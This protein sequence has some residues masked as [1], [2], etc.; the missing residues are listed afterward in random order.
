M[1]SAIHC[2]QSS[3]LFISGVKK[4]HYFP[5]ELLFGLRVIHGSLLCLSQQEWLF[6]L[7]A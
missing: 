2:K 5:L 4:S 7:L 6:L 1:R 3:S